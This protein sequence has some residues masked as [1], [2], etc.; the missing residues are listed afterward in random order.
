MLI[1]ISCL[2]KDRQTL[3]DFKDVRSLVKLTETESGKCGFSGAGKKQDELLF[4]G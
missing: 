3:H 2:H 1:K 4:N